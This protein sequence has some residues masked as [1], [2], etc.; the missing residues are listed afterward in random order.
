MQLSRL[1][2]LQ[3]YI[4]LFSSIAIFSL[5]AFKIIEGTSWINALYFVMVTM[6]TVGFG[7]VTASYTSTKLI[8]LLLIINGLTSIGVASQLLLDRI[9]TFQL[10]K[11]RLL[12]QK[13]IKFENH[14]IIAGYGS[15]GRRLAQ[16]FNDRSYTVVIVDLDDDRAKLA[17]LNDYEVIQGDI[18]KPRVLEILSLDNA[19]ALCLLLSND[20]ITLHTGILARSISENLDIY[21]EIKS[22]TTY[23][24][25]R[26]AGI[27]KPIPF[28]SFMTN[29]IQNHL[30]HAN[31]ELFYNLKELH[32]QEAG[33]GYALI[34]LTLDY[35]DIFP[36]SY[37][38]G[39]FS[40]SLNELYQDYKV[41]VTTDNIDISNHLL[42]AVDRLELIKSYKGENTVQL[43][44]NRIIFAGYSELVDEVIQRLE[45]TEDDV[46]ILWKTEEERDLARNINCKKY[47]LKF[48][49][50]TELLET[51]IMND[52]LVV[53]SLDDITESLLIAVSLRKL[54]RESHLV[55]VVP[56]E[57]EV[58]PFVKVGADAV[59]TPQHVIANAIISIF[60][61]DNQLPPSIIFNNGHIFEHIVQ[62]HDKYVNRKVKDILLEGQQI[63]FIRQP[64]DAKYRAP[65]KDLRIRHNDRIL[66]IV[67]DD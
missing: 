41:N 33:L 15:K 55:Q 24:I 48:E 28:L 20:N 25:A 56:Y 35:Q 39:L 4:A 3:L 34:H 1:P 62:P 37:R 38:L 31:I 57:Y 47:Q 32:Q 52:D 27:N 30:S 13:P 18:T 6:S 60:M 45:H 16:L 66:V 36:E 23:D 63:A 8:T 51:I 59:I 7:D 42:V 46:I 58:E 12:P 19:A 14:V 65:D 49:K 44:H 26:I 17:E 5:V 10:S 53:C 22:T 50:T 2:L 29:E 9:V 67:N 43:L 64:D 54:D 11:A 61:K 21:A 40:I